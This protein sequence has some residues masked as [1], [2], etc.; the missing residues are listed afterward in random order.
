MKKIMGR[1]VIRYVAYSKTFAADKKIHLLTFP[2]EKAHDSSFGDYVDSECGLEGIFLKSQPISTEEYCERF[3]GEMEGFF[4]PT[5]PY[6]FERGRVPFSKGQMICEKCKMDFAAKQRYSDAMTEEVEEYI[7]SPP[8][9]ATNN[10]NR[11]GSS[12]AKG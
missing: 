8:T 1:T 10:N 7:N 11:G 2:D 4:I 5:S 9:T 3:N 6:D 12:G